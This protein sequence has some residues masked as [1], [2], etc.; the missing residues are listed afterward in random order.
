MQSNNN[1][2]AGLLLYS[3]NSGAYITHNATVAAA[4]VQKYI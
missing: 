3:T 4:L 2:I 1:N